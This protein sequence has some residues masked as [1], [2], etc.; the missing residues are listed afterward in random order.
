M[1]MTTTHCLKSEIA[2]L[3]DSISNYGE[4]LIKV[5][6]IAAFQQEKDQIMTHNA[7]L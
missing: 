1:W 7:F 4:S 2:A 3:S 5:T 6:R